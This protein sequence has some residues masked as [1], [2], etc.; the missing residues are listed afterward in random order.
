MP[1]SALDGRRFY[2]FQR[3]L[4]GWRPYY[5]VQLENKSPV[6]GMKHCA[7]KTSPSSLF[8]RQGLQKRLGVQSGTQYEIVLTE[9]VRLT[10]AKFIATDHEWCAFRRC[11]GTDK[12][13]ALT[14]LDAVVKAE[15]A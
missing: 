11:S 9:S 15:I 7:M 1:L 8:Q 3:E 2:V 14:A 12:K 4:R 6:F 10:D 5:L 13:A